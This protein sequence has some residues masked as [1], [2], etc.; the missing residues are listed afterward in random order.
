V[1]YSPRRLAARH[2]KYRVLGLVGRGQFG[3]VHCAIDRRTGQFVALKEVNANRLTTQY[4]LRELRFLATLQHPNIVTWKTC[5]HFQEGRYLVMDYC[6]GGTLRN[7]METQP[8]LP[9]AIIL[10][11]VQDILA[12]LAHVHDQGI[13][14]CDLKP[15]NILLRCAPTGW[16]A[17]ISDFGIARLLRE[18]LVNVDVL[19]AMAGSPAYMAPER[20]D[21]ELNISSDIYAVG[22]LLHELLVG[23]RPFAGTPGALIE[24]HRHQPLRL[25]P[26][27]PTALRS[28][29]QIALHKKPDQ[30]FSSAHAMHQAIARLQDIQ[31]HLEIPPFTETRIPPTEIPHAQ[32]PPAIAPRLTG[33]PAAIEQIWCSGDRIYCIAGQTLY[34][35]ST[36]GNETAEQIQLPE[37][38]QFVG[39]SAQF[40]GHRSGETP[41]IILATDQYLGQLQVQPD[42]T[43]S[44]W[45][46]LQALSPDSQIALDPS[47][48]WLALALRDQNDRHSLEI[49]RMEPWE[50]CHVIPL[51]KAPWKLIF[52]D[53]RHMGLVYR[54]SGFQEGTHTTIHLLTR[55]GQSMGTIAIPMDLVRLEST[56]RPC[57]L[58]A[59]EPDL[60]PGLLEI[61]LEP[62]SLRRLPLSSP[63]KCLRSAP[64]GYV[65]GDRQAQIQRLNHRGEILDGLDWGNPISAI[66]VLGV[67]QL[68]VASQQQFGYGL[69]QVSWIE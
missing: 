29:L 38:T 64:W 69:H 36:Q 26:R 14:H 49:W 63:P 23:D 46:T 55:K 62:F 58:M 45:Q 53:S 41:R 4:F 20:F 50:R 68:L 10:S 40:I 24:A 28:I 31:L 22:I 33:L 32:I 39:Q 44:P 25:S 19:D 21:G 12:G 52:L 17:H 5:E 60:G 30:R 67:N 1:S 65:M 37:A 54:R 9:C 27:I 57:Q 3:A 66:G 2:S 7:L 18:T 48:Q 56:P 47:G 15:E 16:I 35:L 8:N 13:I 59:L 11:I 42:G 61:N 6:E 43:I 51:E 34:S